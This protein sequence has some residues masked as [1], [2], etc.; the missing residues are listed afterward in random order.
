MRLTATLNR[1]H[2]DFMFQ[3]H[4][5]RQGQRKVQETK[6]AEVLAAHGMNVSDPKKYLE[7]FNK[8]PRVE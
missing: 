8:A 1:Q 2:L 3:R 7:K 5:L 6:A 4:W